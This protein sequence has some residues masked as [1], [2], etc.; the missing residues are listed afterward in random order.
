MPPIYSIKS[1]QTIMQQ[2]QQRSAEWFAQ[3]VGRL[4]GSQ[5]GAALGLSPWQKPDEVI[6]AM[7]REYHGAESEFSAHI[8]ANYGANHE[9][10]AMLCFMRSTDLHVEDCG[11]FEYEEWAGASPDGLIGDDAVFELKVPFGLRNKDVPEFKAIELQ[12]HYYAQVQA[13]MLSTGRKLCYFA[14]YVPARGDIF[15]PDYR[16]EE[17][18][19]E[20]VHLSAEW[21]S[22]NLP[23]LKAFHA[24]YL[25]EL[26]NKEHIEPLRQVIDTDEALSIVNRMGEID[27]A[28]A[29]L[30]D[31]RKEL[32]D[33]L[34][35]VA[36][37]K[38]SE[39]H[40][41]K[42]TKVERSGSISY[43]KAIKE[44]A[45][46][47]DLEKWRGKPSSSWRFS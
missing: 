28:L 20:L 29:N 7:V 14:Q 9:R 42:L 19:V 8:P 11:F 15:S 47:A 43:A 10:Q 22:E 34:I 32:L 38:D 26:S 25:S 41:H 35:E 6:R 4:T 40:G 31:E 21:L 2:D 37:G 45:P 5:W 1:E 13:E 16:E 23:K 36:G 33:K 12:P 39:I 27:E 30:S 17:I 46:D 18:E 3:R 44:L 24:R